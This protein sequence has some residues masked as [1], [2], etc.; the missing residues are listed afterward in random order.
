MICHYFII[1]EILNTATLEISVF[2]CIHIYSYVYTCTP[3]DIRMCT[4]TYVCVYV[5][6]ETGMS[7]YMKKQVTQNYPLKSA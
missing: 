4:H 3:T 6:T 2:V 7:T 5:H 1:K